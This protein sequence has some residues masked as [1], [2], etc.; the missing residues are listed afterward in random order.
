[1]FSGKPGQASPG[2][3]G[4]GGRGLIS[5]HRH[6]VENRPKA[7]AAGSGLVPAMGIVCPSACCSIFP[8]SST[9]HWHFLAP[10]RPPIHVPTFHWLPWPHLSPGTA[11]TPANPMSSPPMTPWNPRP[12]ALPPAPALWPLYLLQDSARGSSYK[13]LIPTG[14]LPARMPT[15]PAFPPPTSIPGTHLRAPAALASPHSL[16]RPR[17]FEKH[18]P[19]FSPRSPA[20]VVAHT[21]CFPSCD[22][23]LSRLPPQGWVPSLPT[24]RALLSLLCG[25]VARSIQRVHPCGTSVMPPAG[26]LACIPTP[27]HASPSPSPLG[28]PPAS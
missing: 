17:A 12:S 4:R 28:P 23:D 14:L 19:F 7:T 9:T 10:R 26:T 11:K 22:K 1:M 8:N 3:G 20:C 6:F 27:L 15:S 24:P 5:T 25:C 21:I 16:L 2:R 18:P 13:S